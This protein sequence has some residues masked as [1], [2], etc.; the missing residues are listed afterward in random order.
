LPIVFCT[1]LQDVVCI[2]I[3]NI[4]EELL[5]DLND[6]INDKENEI[7]IIDGAK[8]GIEDEIKELNTQ[9]E[10]ICVMLKQ[11]IHLRNRR[12]TLPTDEKMITDN[13]CSTRYRRRNE[14][15]NIL[16]FLHG[17][18]FFLHI[19]FVNKSVSSS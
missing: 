12:E 7:I 1:N 13:F 4:S 3:I 8:K 11:K 18:F 19:Y 10:K 15:K 14:T 6:K 9:Y 5:E 2:L 16:Q 17:G